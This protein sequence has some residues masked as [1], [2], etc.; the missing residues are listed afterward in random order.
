MC[1][2]QALTSRPPKCYHMQL[3]RKMDIIGLARIGIGKAN[4]AS[5]LQCTESLPTDRQLAYTLV[6]QSYTLA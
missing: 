5:S 4:S 1:T 3:R 6:L 2:G